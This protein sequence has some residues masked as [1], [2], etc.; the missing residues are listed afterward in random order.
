LVPLVHTPCQI[1]TNQV[2]LP[3]MCLLMPIIPAP[4]R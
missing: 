4:I 2:K 3:T 1:V